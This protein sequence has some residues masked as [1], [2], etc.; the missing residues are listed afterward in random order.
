M[1]EEVIKLHDLVCAHDPSAIS[2]E[3][4]RN[5]AMVGADFDQLRFKR[6]MA[7]LEGIFNGSYPGFQASNTPYH[8]LEHTN[9]VVLATARLLHG[10]HLDDGARFSGSQLLVA[11]LA[12]MFHDTGLIPKDEETKGS[13]AR[14]LVGHEKRSI[15]LAAAYMRENGF[16]EAERADCGACIMATSLGKPL[17]EITF[18]GPATALVAK[19]LASADLLAQMA[20]RAYLEKLP[21]LYREFAEAGVEGYRSELDLLRKTI[22]FYRSH[23]HPR[24]LLELGN[25]KRVLQTHFR[26]RWGIDRDLYDEAIAGNL[27]YLERLVAKCGDAYGCYQENLHRG[28]FEG[29]GEDN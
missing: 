16:S 14:Y 21:L 19:V 26:A 6:A 20:D 1:R 9:A 3:I 13:G 29:T 17:A 8:N 2:E 22:D 12:A 10:L 25:V 28:G 4:C 23:A 18:S 15:A 11:L 27:A 7:D 24:L 5:V